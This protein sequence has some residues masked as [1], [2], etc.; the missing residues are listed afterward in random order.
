MKSILGR[1]LVTTFFLFASTFVFAANVLLYDDLIYPDDTWG[2]ALAPHNVTRVFDDGSFNAALLGT[3]DLVVV[4]FDDVDHLV[5]LDTYAGTGKLIY[6]NWFDRYDGAVG[7][8]STT[9]NYLDLAITSSSLASGLSL[10][11]QTLVDP[12]Y[13]VISRG[14]S[15]GVSLATFG[16]ANGIV[17]TNGGLTIVNGFQGNTF[18]SVSDEVQLYQNEVNFLL[19]V[20]AVP[21]PAEASMMLLGI[22][23]LAAIQRRKQKRLYALNAE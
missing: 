10:A 5:N 21:E 11:N 17:F 8:T 19:N 14:F 16:S 9:L 4:Q 13:A 23:V 3:F 18:A 2:L 7:V 12:F 20:S 1:T 15:N 6:A 22:T